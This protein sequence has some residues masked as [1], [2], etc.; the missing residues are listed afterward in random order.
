[1]IRR[2]ARRRRACSGGR[3]G[4]GGAAQAQA[5]AARAR[6]A[7]AGVAGAGRTPV[8][9]DDPGPEGSL[10]WPQRRPQGLGRREQTERAF[11]FYCLALPDEGEQRLVEADLDQLFSAPMTRRAAE[12]LRGRLRTPAAGLPP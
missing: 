11:L 7:P 5:A 9:I 6:P 8:V 4:R 10:A 12:Y 2:P 3:V 1:M